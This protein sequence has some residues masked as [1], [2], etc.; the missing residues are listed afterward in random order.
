MLRL[1]ILIFFFAFFGKSNGQSLPG[2]GNAFQ[3][4]GV[5]FVSIP[6]FPPVTFPLSVSAWIKVDNNNSFQC[7]FQSDGTPGTGYRGFRFQINPNMVLHMGIGQGQ[8]GCYANQCTRWWSGQMPLSFANNWIHVAAVMPN[9]NTCIMYLNGNQIP[10]FSGGTG[11]FVMATSVNPTANIGTYITTSPISQFTG[12][13]D[14]VAIWSIALT[15]AQ[16]REFMCKRVPATTPGLEA[17]YRFDEPNGVAVIDQGPNSKNGTLTNPN[18]R[19]VSGAPIGDESAY[20]YPPAGA[21]AGLTNVFNDV[22]SVENFQGTSGGVHIYSVNVSPNHTN[23]IADSC[24]SNRY[25]GVFPANTI[26]PNANYNM[27]LTKAIANTGNVYA[28]NNN[29]TQAWTN[30]GT[31]N[32]NGFLLPFT[33]RT[34]AIITESISYTSGL[35][36]TVIA[37]P[38]PVW[39]VPNAG[40]NV[41]FSWSTGSTADSILVNTGGM[42][43]LTAVS[44]CL[45]NPVV[46]TVYVIAPGTS[47]YT[48]GLPD[49]II[50]CPLPIWLV[51]NPNP[52]VSFL[53]STGSTADSIL[54]SAVGMYILSSSLPCLAN[55]I[56]DTVY[57]IA[58]VLNQYTS[59]LPDTIIACPLPIWLVPNPNPNVSFL[60]STGA[61]TDSLQVNTQGIYILTASMPCMS[62]PTIDT[63]Y[64][65]S[66]GSNQYVSGLPD[67]IKTCEMPIWLVPNPAPNVSFSWSTGSTSDSLRV[68][69]SG[70][71]VLTSSIPCFIPDAIDTVYVIEENPG[72][73]PFVP[74]VY[75]PNVFTPNGDGVND[76]FTIRATEGAVDLTIFN[77]WGEEVYFDKNY[78]GD[79]DGTYQG[80]P[81]AE[82]V[83]A[84]R[85]D[86][87]YFEKICLSQNK[88]IESRFGFV[89]IMR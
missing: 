85:V 88:K 30:V 82:G 15:P 19:V 60:W 67:T 76:F 6:N 73:L 52:N 72:Q 18:I 20:F 4:N 61:T 69:T 13:I 16:I 71:Y 25:F 80:K 87:T 53:W 39:L 38:L 2:S 65:I 26:N 36:D 24:L 41:S 75:I 32:A 9:V 17:V 50:A 79:W 14:E 28:R 22:I 57:V 33:T 5:A 48:S 64:V 59:G 49:T 58:P 56:V 44:P 29:A 3:G 10:N 8:T 21:T 23:G 31:T 62:N 12:Q 84:Y 35:P 47:Q 37:C 1:R 34:E 40:Q 27:R 81:L 89:H 74:E 45:V 43:I 7:I 66:Q 78:Q 55:P 11:Q 70:V 54:V 63:V 46:D 68:N 77:R 86:Y 42:F 83:Y 51:P